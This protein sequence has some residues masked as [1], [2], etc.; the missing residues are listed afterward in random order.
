MKKIFIS[1]SMRIKRI[2]RKVKERID[3]IINSN[4]PILLGDANGADTS[5]QELIRSKEYE[6]VTIYCSGDY[7]RNN[8]GRWK[9][10]KIMT[11]CKK[12]TRLFFTAKDIQM[13]KECDYGLMVW[14][15]KSTGTLSNVYE[16][17][18]QGKKSLLFVNK[19]KSF[20]KVT[21]I[22]EF[23]KLT[24]FMSNSAFEKADKKIQLRKKIQGLK[25][26]QTDM[27]EANPALNR[28][29][30]AT[31]SQTKLSGQPAPCAG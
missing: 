29:Q 14:D 21:D 11:D 12:N 20:I 10:R 25:C 7:A 19:M 31:G 9:V 28:T 23:E 5:I 15:S 13:A 26:R 22:D 24:S 30:G 3:N 4:F 6:K 8:I 2:D 27:F 17:V 16:L 1:G 18:S